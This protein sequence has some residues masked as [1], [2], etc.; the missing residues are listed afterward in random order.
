MA[1]CLTKLRS[2]LRST[3]LGARCLNFELRGQF[4]ELELS[5]E[6]IL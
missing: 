1:H 4:S 2:E 5:L 6:F 3:E